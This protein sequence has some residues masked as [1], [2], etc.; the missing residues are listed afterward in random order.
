MSRRLPASVTWLLVMVEN[1]AERQQPQI[2]FLHDLAVQSTL[3]WASSNS[4][5]AP[6]NR[7]RL[8]ASQRGAASIHREFL[9]RGRHHACYAV[10]HDLD[11]SAEALRASSAVFAAK[12]SRRAAIRWLSEPFG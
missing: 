5:F 2:D 11:P 6:E 7:N 1:K 10:I 8:V 12:R 3:P 4:C 9:S